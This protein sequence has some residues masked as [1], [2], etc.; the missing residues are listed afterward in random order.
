MLGILNSSYA[1]KIIFVT[2]NIKFS[3]Y[4]SVF[5]S[6]IVLWIK[7]TGNEKEQDATF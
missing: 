1:L 4:I 5:K 3:P 6:I 7:C 2:L